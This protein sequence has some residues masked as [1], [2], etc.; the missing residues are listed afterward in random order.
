MTHGGTVTGKFR[1]YVRRKSIKL[2][3]P[4]Y[5]YT[6]PCVFSFQ[7]KDLILK[8]VQLLLLVGGNSLARRVIDEPEIA[9]YSCTYSLG[10]TFHHG[11]GQSSITSTV[12]SSK[13]TC[14]VILA[15]ESPQN[16]TAFK[17]NS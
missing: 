9:I 8:A 12:H 14:L 3:Q 17:I 13:K 11:G 4:I 6:Y 15:S 10:T 1:K 16:G 2:I 7:K 5:R